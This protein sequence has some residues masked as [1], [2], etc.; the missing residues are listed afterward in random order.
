MYRVSKFEW[1]SLLTLVRRL[2][3]KK[4]SGASRGWTTL[5]TPFKGRKDLATSLHNLWK[6]TFLTLKERIIKSSCNEERKRQSCFCAQITHKEVFSLLRWRLDIAF[7]TVRF[8]H[9]VFFFLS[10][11]ASGTIYC[12]WTVI[13]GLWTVPNVWTVT[14]ILFLLFLIFSK[15][16]CI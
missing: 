5:G 11:H 10:G 13:L 4:A 14:F 2:M 9:F 16:N 6:I 1:A 12:P 8:L 3:M 15:I 7:S